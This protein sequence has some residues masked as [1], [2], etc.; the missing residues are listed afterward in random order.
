MAEYIKGA[1]LDDLTVTWNDPDG[2]PYDFSSGF[3][4]SLK[5]GEKG[6]AATFTKTTGI[7]GAATSPNVTVV[8]ATTGELNSLAAGTHVLQLE[9][10]RT[11]DLR[12]HFM[13]ASIKIVDAVL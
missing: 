7:T 3:T 11:S 10:I 13:Q 8:W 2:E 12:S 1:E 5:V 9:A 4:F 6:Q